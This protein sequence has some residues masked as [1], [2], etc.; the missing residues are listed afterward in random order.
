MIEALINRQRLRPPKSIFRMI[1]W[2]TYSALKWLDNTR[3]KKFRT[4]NRPSCMN[5]TNNCLCV[6][7]YYKN[8]EGS[9]PF[10]T[11]FIPPRRY[12]VFLPSSPD[13]R[14]Q[15]TKVGILVSSVLCADQNSEPKLPKALTNYRVST[16][17]FNNKI[18]YIMCGQNLCY[19][20][21]LH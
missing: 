17:S 7:K 15:L 5:T 2:I 9:R 14:L 13:V 12:G 10:A 20:N 1:G 18:C 21:C 4:K 16:I 3:V 11:G 8:R 6:H 19:Q